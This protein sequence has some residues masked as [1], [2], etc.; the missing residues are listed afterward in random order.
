MPRLLILF[1]ITFHPAV[2]AIDFSSQSQAS[3]VVELYTSEGCSSCPPADRWLST[4]KQ[5]D[6]LFDS[7]LPMAFHVDYWDKLGWP[8]RFATADNSNRQRSLVREDLISQVYT[9]GI[10]INS[11]EWH[12]WFQGKRTPP[13]NTTQ[14]G[15][16]QASLNGNTLVVRFEQ[17]ND[18]VL[19]MA[20]L[21]VGL[22]TI[23]K[24]GENKGKTL[25]H[26]FVVLDHWQQAGKQNWHVTV[27]TV[28][29][30]GQQQTALAI[31]LTEPGSLQIIQATATYID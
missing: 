15:P 2:W 25:K 22:E 21:G 28:P 13:V 30:K 27:P 16:L 8:D 23:V 6:A 31:W 18:L 19:N 4:L 1:L 17:P 12:G 24:A 3:T 9:P 11:E 7:I 20:W 26:D 5:D 14:P 10:V 29:D